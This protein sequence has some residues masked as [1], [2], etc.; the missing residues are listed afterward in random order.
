MFLY[1][2]VLTVLFHNYW[3]ASE[4]MAGIQK[5]EF[6]KNLGIAGGLLMLAYAG[7]GAWSL[8]KIR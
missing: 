5:T 7:P 6:R 4:H 2:I 3:T 8:G 1:L